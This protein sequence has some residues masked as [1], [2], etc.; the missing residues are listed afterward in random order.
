MK[1]FENL[2]EDIAY[3]EKA[4][5]FYKIPALVTL[6]HEVEPPSIICQ[7]LLD[8]LSTHIINTQEIPQG[9]RL[10]A[11]D[12]PSASTRLKAT[13]VPLTNFALKRIRLHK[14][15]AHLEVGT[16]SSPAKRAFLVQMI[17]DAVKLM[18]VGEYIGPAM[19]FITQLCE[20]FSVLFSDK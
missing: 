5:L 7:F 4:N 10:L 16:R 3:H 2:M 14:F 18:E 20:L 13:G 1:T 9:R 17:K 11:L 6:P 12:G 8:L 19:I 15:I